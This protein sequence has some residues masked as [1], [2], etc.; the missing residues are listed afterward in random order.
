MDDI[1]V[2][3]SDSNAIYLLKAA[4][5][6]IKEQN[7]QPLGINAGPI[8]EDARRSLTGFILHHKERESLRRLTSLKLRQDIEA[9]WKDA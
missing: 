2:L 4:I 8:M 3:V 9:Y 5:D 1:D 7:R 6:T